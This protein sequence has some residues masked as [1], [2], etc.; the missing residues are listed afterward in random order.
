MAIATE[1]S[2]RALLAKSDVSPIARPLDAL[3]ARAPG[4][5]DVMGGIADYC[6]SV[7]LEGTLDLAAWVAVEPREDADIVVY[8]RQ[9]EAEGWAAEVRMGMHKLAASRY[10]EL[11]YTLVEEKGAAWATYVLGAVPVLVREGVI[12]PPRKGMSLAIHSDVP[13][14]AGVSSSAAL[15]VASMSAIQRLLGFPLDGL[16][17]A[18]LCQIVENRV[19]G[20][21]CGIMDQVTS[22]LGQESGLLALRCQPHDVLGHNPLPEGWGVY[23]INSAV[24]HAVGG[25]RYTRARVG[26]F[27][28]LRII[29]KDL[30]LRPRGGYLCNITPE[31]YTAGIRE[32]LPAKMRGCEFKAKYGKTQDTVTTVRPDMTYSVRG[33]AE[34]PIYENRRVQDFVDLMHDGSR[35]AA[36]R[37]GQL[38]YGSHWSYGNRAGLGCAETDLIV[39][40]VKERGPENGLVGAKITGGG[41]GGTVAILTY[42]DAHAAVCETAAEYSRLS[43]NAAQVFSGSSPGAVS[44]LADAT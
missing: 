6:G 19:A 29:T 34:H 1:K 27:M 16:D 22:A 7:V 2:F 28:G 3:V 39:R 30:G 36:E 13:L 25:G 14:G 24:K 18:R 10:D 37:A 26:A 11:R 44:W 33:C 40:L 42:G 32:R 15:E 35:K 38:M 12:K 21:P 8:S 23:G 17:M 9:A 41:S 4:R 20:A 31:Q 5:L 43:G